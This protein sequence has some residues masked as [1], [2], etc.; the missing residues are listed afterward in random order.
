MQPHANVVPAPGGGCGDSSWDHDE[1]GSKGV[2]WETSKPAACLSAAAIVLELLLGR[3]ESVAMDT[4]TMERGAV[5]GPRRTTHGAAVVDR[6]LVGCSKRAAMRSRMT[7][8]RGVVPMAVACFPVLL[9]ARRRTQAHILPAAIFCATVCADCCLPPHHMLSLTFPNSPPGSTVWIADS[10]SSVDGTGSGKFVYNKRRPLPAEALLLTD[11]GRKLKMECLGLLDVVLHCKDDVQVTLETAAVVPGLAFDRMSFNCIQEKHDI[12]VNRDGTWILN[13]RVHFVKLPAGNYIQATRVEHGAGP[14]A[15]M[16][17]MMRPGQQRSISSDDLHMSFGHTNDANAR[18]TAKQIGIKLAGTR[19]YCDGC[20]GAKAIRRA[21]PRETK[22]KSERSLQRVFID[23]TG[24]Y[25]PSAGGARYCMLMMD[26]NTNVAWPLFLRDKSG[27]TLFHAFR[28]WH[29]AVKLVAATYGGLGIA[30]FDDEHEFA[31]AE[32]RKLLTE[33]GI[34]IEY[35][36]IDGAKRNGRVERKLA[37]VAE[38]AKAAWLK[39]PRHFPDL[40]FPNKTLWWIAIWPEAI[41]WMND[42]LNMTAQ[43]YM[44]DNL[45]PWENLYKRRATSLPLL[46]MMPGFHRRNRKNKTKS[47]DKRCFCL[48][49]DHS[50]ITHKILLSSGVCNYSADVTWGY[51]HRAPFVGEVP[52]WGG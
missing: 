22:V 31:N 7:G 37:L 46:F 9:G 2:T 6:S 17:A 42:C 10:V 5:A 16:A 28:A 32:F 19:G 12:L 25:P 18:D 29:N 33:L 30:R 41:A 15:M 34:T 21:V 1:G 26:D 3:M 36:P 47:K 27:P 48:N 38:G 24:P 50:S 4:G 8:Q 23:L 39:F 43:A 51:R 20:G 11:D 13:G 44:P 40:E 14:P 52:T 35:T 49:T 45:C